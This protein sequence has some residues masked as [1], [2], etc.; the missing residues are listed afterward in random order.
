MEYPLRF[1][2]RGRRARGGT[3]RGQGRS[4]RGRRAWDGLCRSR[5]EKL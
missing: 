1:M 2:H 3:C 4:G 5:R